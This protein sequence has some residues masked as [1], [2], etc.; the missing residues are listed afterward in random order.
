MFGIRIL[1]ILIGIALI[2]VILKRLATGPRRVATGKTDEVDKMVQCKH[3]GIYLPQ[4]EAL[5]SGDHYFCNEQHRQD[6]QE[7][8]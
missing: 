2:I 5:K 8:H 4:K 6:D 7:S 3:C 1:L